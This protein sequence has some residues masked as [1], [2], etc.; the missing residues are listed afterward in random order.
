[1]K[2]ISS[3]TATVLSEEVQDLKGY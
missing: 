1:L 3:Y 2:P